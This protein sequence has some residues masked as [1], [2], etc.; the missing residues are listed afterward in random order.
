M[1]KYCAITPYTSAR[2]PKGP[3]IGRAKQS[4][5]GPRYRDRHADRPTPPTLPRRDGG[6]TAAGPVALGGRAA[7]RRAGAGHGTDLPLVRRPRSRAG[8]DRRPPRPGRRRRDHRAGVHA[9]RGRP[10]PRARVLPRR[11]VLAGRARPLRPRLPGHEPRAPRAWW[12]R[13]TTAWRPSIA[14]RRR[15]TT[16]TRRRSGVP[17]MPRSS[18]STR[19]ASPSAATAPAATSPPSSP[20]WRAIAAARSSCSSS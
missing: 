12:C 1:A 5:D 16:A 17:R 11:C 20:R 18:A 6:R 4:R 10:L 2:Q 14:I 3:R 19:R 13:S 7:G 15:P 8:G 9:P